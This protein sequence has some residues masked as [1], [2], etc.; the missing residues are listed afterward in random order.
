M[1]YSKH[2]TPADVKVHDYAAGYLQQFVKIES[3]GPK[4][5]ASLLI[6]VLF[7]IAAWRTSI[8][9]ACQR[10]RRAPSDEAVRQALWATLPHLRALEARFNRAFAAQVP[11]GLRKRKRGYPLI[12]DLRETPYYG[13]PYRQPRELR[14][15]K[16]KQGTCRFHTVATVYLLSHGQRLTLGM[17]YV[18]G[19]DALV[20]VLARLLAQVR[21]I[22]LRIRYLLL[23]RGFYNVDVV[24]YL[25]RVHCPF[26]MPVARRGRRPKDPAAAAS[27]WR[28]FVWKK[29]GW[30]THTMR[31]QRRAVEVKI[32]VACDNYAGR[33]GRRG[34]RTL[35]FAFWDFQPASP[36]W[37]RET[38]RKRFGIESSYRQMEQAR[39]RTSSRKPVLRLL[40]V[41]LALLLRNAWVWYHF[42]YLADQFR[43]GD[44]WV[45]LEKLRFRTI[46]LHLL[47]YA[48]SVAG[49]LDSTD[50]Q[51]P[52]LE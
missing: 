50:L 24:S 23:D 35:V 22:G 27:V 7:F 13:K 26:L 10:L 11:K 43:G 14:A 45:H 16:A 38:Y 18:Q 9:D 5:T 12:I 3:H 39:A 46:L 44:L 1:R 41:G 17:T 52:L 32:C 30:S 4:C 37:V 31:R 25:K 40:Y 34:R 51:L 28:F 42:T 29:S 36:R 8:A 15:G 48:A 20:E 47:C 21:E 49:P 33:Q 2:S 19:D 6:S